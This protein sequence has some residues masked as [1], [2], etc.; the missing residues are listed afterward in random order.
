MLTVSGADYFG[1]PIII[2]AGR[3]AEEHRPSYLRGEGT[4]AQ[5]NLNGQQSL[6]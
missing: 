1:W 6:Y 3:F 4:N 5:A 2:C